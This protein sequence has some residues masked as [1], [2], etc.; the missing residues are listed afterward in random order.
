VQLSP[1]TTIYQAHEGFVLR[2]AD[3]EHFELTL[4]D[5]DVKQLLAALTGGAPH[6][7]ARVDAALGALV[8]AG[9]VVTNAVLPAVAVRGQGRIAAAASKRLGHRASDSAYDADFVCHLSDEIIDAGSI[10]EVDLASYRDG[11]TQVITPSAADVADVMGRRRAC[12]VHRDRMQSK[13]RPVEGGL[14]VESPLHPVS[15]RAADMI[16][17]LIVAEIADR[18]SRPS[19][20]R[21]SERSHYLLTTIDLRSLEVSRHPVLPIPAAPQ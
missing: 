5:D 16:A 10:G 12:S 18:Q 2:T 3:D 21:A 15:D 11:I 6:A 20:A 14:R 9:H 1:N 8:D 17:D 19:R 4:P 13:Y 7:S